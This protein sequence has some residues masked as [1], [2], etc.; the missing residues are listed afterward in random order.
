MMTY[1]GGG[2]LQRDVLV[3]TNIC[4]SIECLGRECR[5][6]LL[7]HAVIWSFKCT[8]SVRVATKSAFISYSIKAFKILLRVLSGVHTFNRPSFFFAALE[9]A[10]LGL[11][12]I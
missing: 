12:A 9:Y 1:Q 4:I 3:K 5:L 7:S 11:W 6:P 10:N 2:C 8:V